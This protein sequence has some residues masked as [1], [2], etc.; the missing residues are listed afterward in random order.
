[1]SIENSPEWRAMRA[2][3]TALETKLAKAEE[4]TAAAR[5]TRLKTDALDALRKVGVLPDRIDHA[6][7]WL[8]DKGRFAFSD[9]GGG[10]A[11]VF[12][13]GENEEPLEKGL[14]T[15]ARSADASLYF[16]AIQPNNAPATPA[17]RGTGAAK[18]QSAIEA[19]GMEMEEQLR[20]AVRYG[21]PDDSV[22]NV[23]HAYATLFAE[24][25]VVVR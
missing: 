12:K 10:D 5:A 11:I 15:W 8:Q 13:Q 20:G 16:P 9:E 3:V 4:V 23:K 17:M 24:H 14:E 7:A 25:G 22:E 21:A 6:L 18:A 19:M 2:Q 1:M